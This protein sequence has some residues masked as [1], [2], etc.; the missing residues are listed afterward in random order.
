V[1]FLGTHE[2]SWLARA[3]VPLFV[4]HRRLAR[5]KKLPARALAPWALD[6][7]GFTELSMHGR[8]TVEPEAY[9]D[10]VR[11]YRDGIGLLQWAA[12]QDWMCEPA[13]RR[14][15]GKTVEEHQA[16]TIQ[17][18]LDMRRIAPDLPWAP[19]LQGWAPEDY[20]LH[21]IAYSRAGVDLAREPI[22]GVGSVCRRQATAEA[23]K[24]IRGLA[25]HGLKLHG[26]GFKILGLRRVAD[27]LASSD[28]MAWS[29]GARRRPP[30][31]GH[32]HVS[33]SNCI[34]YAL[35]WR[36]RLVDSIPHA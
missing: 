12:I 19:V 36:A 14:E 31:D 24:I 34:G 13:I 29:F 17:S 9:A 32:T 26:F 25:A 21:R 11:R 15:T 5:T 6:S 20:E 27:V 28:S 7:G 33:C 8:W 16:L 18:L 1:F 2:T 22:V 23:E 30:M 10:A 4:S 3:G 35:A